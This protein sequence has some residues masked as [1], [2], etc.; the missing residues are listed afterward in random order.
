MKL[1][2]KMEKLK[3]KIIVKYCFELK[4]SEKNLYENISKMLAI[5]TNEQNSYTYID[6]L[7]NA[8]SKDL[9]IFYLGEA[10]RD[11]HSILNKGFE[12]EI[13]E[14]EAKQILFNEIKRDIDY[15]N[16]LADRKKIREAVSLISAK[17]LIILGKLKA[18]E[19]K[20]T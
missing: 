10:M 20:S 11:Y 7:R 12:K 5:L 13:D 17:A 8:V 14:T 16:S 15:L 4:M 1:F 9:A 6:K 2:H 19:V 18:E 3:Y